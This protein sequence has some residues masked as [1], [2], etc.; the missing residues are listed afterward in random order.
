[1]K[2]EM[3]PA[4]RTRVFALTAPALAAA[5]ISFTGTAS[6]NPSVDAVSASPPNQSGPPSA[7]TDQPNAAGGAV[8][9]TDPLQAYPGDAGAGSLTPDNAAAAGASPGAAASASA[10][11][12]GAPSQSYDLYPVRGCSLAPPDQGW[13][14]EV[15]IG[16]GPYECREIA[17][18]P[19][20]HYQT[21]TNWLVYKDGMK[22][23]SNY[24]ATYGQTM[25]DN[26]GHQFEG[27]TK[28]VQIDPAEFN[29]HSYESLCDYKD[30]NSGPLHKVSSGSGY[31]YG[32]LQNWA[33]HTATDDANCAANIV[34]TWNGTSDWN[35]VAIN[36]SG[37]FGN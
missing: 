6:A 8:V 36:C 33:Y 37:V 26:G 4:T 19:S 30:T 15:C 24:S 25:V 5:L 34:G 10:S 14:N 32:V 7:S 22:N 20:L 11:C 17:G 9:S 3:I 35:D 23:W 16:N 21:T 13:K 29:G 27:C 28:W 18:H 12:N 31:F 1:M 2:S